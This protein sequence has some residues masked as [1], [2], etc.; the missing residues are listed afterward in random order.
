VNVV[1]RITIVNCSAPSNAVSGWIVTEEDETIFEDEEV[2]DASFVTFPNG[3]RLVAPDPL[4]P[5]QWFEIRYRR[6]GRA[7][8]EVMYQM[9]TSETEA[10]EYVRSKHPDFII[11]PPLGLAPETAKASPIGS[12]W[13]FLQSLW[14]H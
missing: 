13:L 2:A 5:W 9:H 10:V 11:P 6:K 1:S 8:N 7:T 14:T 4:G 12:I 3:P